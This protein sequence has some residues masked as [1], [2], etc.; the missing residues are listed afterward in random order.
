MWRAGLRKP[1]AKAAWLAMHKGKQAVQLRL[2][3]R[4]RTK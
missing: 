2:V 1:L 4:M 3:R